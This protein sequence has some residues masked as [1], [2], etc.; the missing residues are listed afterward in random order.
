MAALLLARGR[1]AESK[2]LLAR[3]G[4]GRGPN[5]TRQKARATGLSLRRPPGLRAVFRKRFNVLR[6]PGV[7][8]PV[9]TRRPSAAPALS[10]AAVHPVCTAT[11][12]HHRRGGRGEREGIPAG[13]LR[14]PCNSRRQPRSATSDFYTPPSLSATAVKSPS[15]PGPVARHDADAELRWRPDSGQH[16]HHLSLPPTQACQH[17]TGGEDRCQRSCR[18]SGTVV[19][20]AGVP[21]SSGA[22]AG[23]WERS[24][25]VPRAN[26][27]LPER[28]WG[29]G[30]GVREVFWGTKKAS[31]SEKRGSE[32][33]RRAKSERQRAQGGGEDGS[34]C[35]RCSLLTALKSAAVRG[36]RNVPPLPASPSPQSGDLNLPSPPPLAHPALPLPLPLPLPTALP[37]R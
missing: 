28:V 23:P 21:S 4:V 17:G 31:E 34:T 26:E 15:R 1:G 27:R 24:V 19:A 8:R 2:L 3:G 16:D 37:P 30:R 9:R 35:R 29:R 11:C 13:L 10:Q 32:R 36:S 22:S 5:H 7:H 12:N 33:G 14:L 6:E 25:S 18:F 20:A